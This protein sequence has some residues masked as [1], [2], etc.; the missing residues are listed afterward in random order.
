MLILLRNVLGNFNSVLILTDS[1]L[2]CE[3]LN[4]GNISRVLSDSLPFIPSYIE[5]VSFTERR[6]GNMALNLRHA[7]GAL[8]CNREPHPPSFVTCSSCEV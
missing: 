3:P 2:V 5:G 6:V 7:K 8:K 1:T 4:A